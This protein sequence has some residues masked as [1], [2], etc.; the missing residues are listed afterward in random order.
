M[1]AIDGEPANVEAALYPTILH[2]LTA[3][4]IRC[5]VDLVHC[6][7]VVEHIEEAHLTKLLATLTSGDVILMSHAMPDQPG[8]HHVNCQP[9]EYWIRKLAEC[10][11]NWLQ[12]DTERIRRMAA[13][14]EAFHLA[15]SGLVFARALTP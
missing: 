5:R 2:D 13:Q 15:R 8:Y 11:F 6:Q 9:S 4:A 10:N 12:I 1:V 3:S 7:E 14:D